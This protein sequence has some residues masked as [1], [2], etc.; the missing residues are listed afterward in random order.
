[1][2][3]AEPPVRVIPTHQGPGLTMTMIGEYFGRGIRCDFQ[4][5]PGPGGVRRG[6]WIAGILGVLVTGLFASL[7][8]GLAWAR[9]SETL[10]SSRL[11]EAH[12]K[13]ANVTRE[14]DRLTR[15][16]HD[17]TIQSIY[18]V[19]FDLQRVRNLI[20][21]NPAG[22]AAELTHT[23]ATLN[24]VVIELREFIQDAEPGPAAIQNVDTVLQ[25]LV[26]RTRLN[27]HAQILLELSPDAAQLVPPRQAVEVLQIV[28]EALTNSLRHGYPRQI[29]IALTRDGNDWRLTIADDGS[30]FD[31]QLINGRDGHGLRNLHERAAELGGEC[32]IVSAPGTG[33][34]VRVIF[35]VLVTGTV[36]HPAGGEA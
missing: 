10:T 35:P 32:I 13:L 7:V 19:G 30:G 22:A 27:T 28:R 31:P 25:A 2:G 11:R 21:R 15:D 8:W 9:Q 1:M 16:L 29:G 14:R 20:G 17:G 18:A 24:N 3:S 23:M 6:V 33:T 12:G 36:S 4:G 34:A 26:K 5:N